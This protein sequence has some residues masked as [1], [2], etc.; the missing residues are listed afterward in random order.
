MLVVIGVSRLAAPISYAVPCSGSYTPRV[1]SCHPSFCGR[2]VIDDFVPPSV[3]ESIANMA[4]RGMHGSSAKQGG[5][6][7]FDVNS[8]YR[9]DSDGLGN[10]YVGQMSGKP[11]GSLPKVSFTEEEYTTYGDVFTKIRQALMDNFQLKDLWF[12]APTFM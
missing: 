8:G 3:I 1:P 10:V 5:P 6:V 12:T 11:K 9:L 4:Q 2:A 7:I